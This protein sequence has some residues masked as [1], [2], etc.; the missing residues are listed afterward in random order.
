MGA[1]NNGGVPILRPMGDPIRMHAEAADALSR[2]LFGRPLVEL[3]NGLGEHV[4][5]SARA[6]ITVVLTH[7]GAKDG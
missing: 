5:E 1:G 7:I 2:A 6:V 3:N 4:I